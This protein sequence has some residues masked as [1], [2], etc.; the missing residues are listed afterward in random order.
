MVNA[1]QVAGSSGLR[2]WPCRCEPWS[3]QR[4]G[5]QVTGRVTGRL[6]FD[7]D[8]W[9]RI[10]WR[11]FSGARGDQNRCQEGQVVYFCNRVRYGRGTI[12]D[13]ATKRMLKYI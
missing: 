12:P 11:Y 1:I 10:R 5:C 2:G 3:S 7:G 6:G 8:R 9:C 4:V 13:V